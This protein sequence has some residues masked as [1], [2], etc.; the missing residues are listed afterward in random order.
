VTLNRELTKRQTLIAFFAIGWIGSFAIMAIGDYQ[1]AK[2][3]PSAMDFVIMAV[4]SLL[5][6]PLLALGAAWK[7][8]FLTRRRK[9]K[10]S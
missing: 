8:G 2:Q 5:F 6:A 1:V 4:L 3:I 9:R 7:G 10:D